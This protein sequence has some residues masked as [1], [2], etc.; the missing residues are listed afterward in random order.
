MI[1]SRQVTLW[2]INCPLCGA[3]FPRYPGQLFNGYS[4][5]K[6]AEEALDRHRQERHV[7]PTVYDPPTCAGCG[8]S[9]PIASPFGTDLMLSLR[10]V[11][12]GTLE[13]P[14]HWHATC[15]LDFLDS[16]TY[17]RNT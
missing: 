10:D 8:R 14:E 16:Q 15:H 5:E 9:G 13:H 2:Y 1:F 7:A 17:D 12:T 4:S 11:G 6:A 3:D